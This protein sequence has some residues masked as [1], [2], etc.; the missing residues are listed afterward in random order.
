[1][2]EQEWQDRYKITSLKG[3]IWKRSDLRNRA[4]KIAASLAPEQSRLMIRTAVQIVLDDPAFMR[5][6]SG[7]VPTRVIEDAGM[8]AFLRIRR[9]EVKP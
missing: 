9:Q 1:M 4:V 2:T 8:E 7:M 6:R 5:L 3:T